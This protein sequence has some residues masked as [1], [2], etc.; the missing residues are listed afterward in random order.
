MIRSEEMKLGNY[1][2]CPRE[3]QNPFRVD[4]IEGLNKDWAK[5]GMES[6]VFGEHPV[7]G[8]MKGHG[9]TWE[10]KDLS[11]IILTHTLLARLP[12]K[13][14]YESEWQVKYEHAEHPE[15]VLLFK[16]GKVFF[17][18]GGTHLMECKYLHQLQNIYYA[19]TGVE[20]NVNL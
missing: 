5:V 18:K 19:L 17:L 8:I 2:N 6:P 4:F 10:S 1:F 11:G 9:L 14:Y 3:D 12:F 13:K 20:L 15:L 7:L 16:N